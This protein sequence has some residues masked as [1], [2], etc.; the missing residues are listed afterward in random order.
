MEH[1]VE[2]IASAILETM[3]AMER[4]PWLLE[5]R[6]QHDGHTGISFGVIEERMFILD[7]DVSIRV[8]LT[9]LVEA[10]GRQLVVGHANVPEGHHAAGLFAMIN[11]QPFDRCPVIGE[12]WSGV[13]AVAPAAGPGAMLEAL[14]P[15]KMFDVLPQ[16][17]SYW[18]QIA[19]NWRKLSEEIGPGVPSLVALAEGVARTRAKTESKT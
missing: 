3:E 16:W 17:L 5:S 1:D 11:W 4:M 2:A 9:R 18:W 6:L 8:A 10:D 13:L 12:C 14:G 19:D 7:G 15:R